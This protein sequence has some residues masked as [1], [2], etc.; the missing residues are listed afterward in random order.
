VGRQAKVLHVAVSDDSSIGT[1]VALV[2]VAVVEGADI[3]ARA[4]LKAGSIRAV[5]AAIA[6][7]ASTG[8]SSIAGRLLP[9][10]RHEPG[11]VAVRIGAGQRVLRAPILPGAFASLSVA[12]VEHVPDG[13]SV[14]LDGPGVLAFDGERERVLPQGARATVTV[15]RDGPLVIDVVDTLVCATRQGLFERSLP[16][17]GDGD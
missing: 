11:A 8:L 16:E 6:S 5:V 3:G 1:G 4:V 7:P 15:L 14:Q 9:L 17:A 13:G 2:D 10:S 12:G